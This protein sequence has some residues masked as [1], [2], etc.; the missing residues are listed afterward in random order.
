M[1]VTHR[2]GFYRG[3]YSVSTY[4]QAIFLIPLRNS[5]VGSQ[6]FDVEFWPLVQLHS[7]ILFPCR[8]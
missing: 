8:F 7:E 6:D 3:S 1:E 5:P 2:R 4:R